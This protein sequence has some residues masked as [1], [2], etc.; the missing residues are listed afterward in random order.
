L[1][2]LWKAFRCVRNQTVLRYV[3]HDLVTQTKRYGTRNK[4]VTYVTRH[5]SEFHRLGGSCRN[6]HSRPVVFAVHWG[7]PS[8]QPLF[9]YLIMWNNIFLN[10]YNITII[11]KELTFS[12]AYP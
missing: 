3:L 10:G 5:Y 4:I 11:L 2:D 1:S 9:C 6:H 7:I 12:V 8:L